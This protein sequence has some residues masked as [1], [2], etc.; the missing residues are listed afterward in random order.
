MQL[1]ISVVCV[2]FH[3]ISLYRFQITIQNYFLGISGGKIVGFIGDCDLNTMTTMILVQKKTN[4][5]P[6]IIQSYLS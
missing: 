4:K 1:F 2:L 5:T 6:I 3:I